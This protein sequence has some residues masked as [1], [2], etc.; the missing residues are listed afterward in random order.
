MSTDATINAISEAFWNASKPAVPLED[1]LNAADAEAWDMPKETLATALAVRGLT[2]ANGMVSET[3]DAAP[4]EPVKADYSVFLRR[5]REAV[6]IAEQPLS[7]AELIG[8]TGLSTEA[9]PAAS[10]AHHL[11]TVGVFFIPGAGYWRNPQYASERGEVWYARF[12]SK[13]LRRVMELFKDHGWPLAGADIERL[14]AGEV[15]SRF[16]SVEAHRTKF[17]AVRSMGGGLFIPTGAAVRS[18]IPMTHNVAAAIL[19]INPREGVARDDDV[20]LYKIAAVLE[21]HNLAKVKYT[22]TTRGGRRVRLVYVDLTE[23]GY[24]TLRKIDKRS[25]DEF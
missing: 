16:M 2:L 24:R 23:H 12:T 8:M 7:A 9:V 6:E 17:A 22:T 10:M 14:T 4:L 25:N 15:T 11:R 1:L 21:R 3:G 13:K 5:A 19:D 18:G 20:R